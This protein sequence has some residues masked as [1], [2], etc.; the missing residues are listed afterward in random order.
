MSKI[1]AIILLIIGLGVALYFFNSGGAQ[2]ITALLPVPSSTTSA[3]SS[4][5]SGGP[6][7]TSS[8]SFFSFL[9]SILPHVTKSTS[10]T[11]TYFGPPP[12]GSYPSTPST[13]SGQA[14]SGGQAGQGTSSVPAN[15]TSSP[16]FHLLRIGGAGQSLITLYTYGNRSNSS[17]LDITGWQI[18]TNHGGE[19]IPQI[20]N[21]Y[22][23]TGLTPPSDLIVTLN[24][25]QY[26]YFYSNSSPVNLR[27]NECVGYLN[28]TKQFNPAM[29]NN[30]P[31]VPKADIASFTGQCQN[32]INSL[33]TC[34]QPNMSSIYIP[35]N[36][37]ACQQFLQDNFTYKS[38][39]QE[40]AGDANF[41][42]NQ[43]RI[44]MGSTPLDKYHD[45][46]ELL[47]RNGL[48]VDSYSY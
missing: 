9:L 41:L 43:W 45:N 5:A 21:V 42:S 27:L 26:I 2:K 20:V 13:G 39:E 1:G 4:S 28:T 48:I 7:Q 37:Y 10:T 32:Y 15:S 40:H 35:R 36:D 47:D 31:S 30:C 44:W 14:G 24:Q 25:N 3:A 23:Y 46:V 38:C 22:D 8:N 17:T 19:Y 34:A 6:T 29:P 11:Q 12:G 16:Y 33:Y 18:K